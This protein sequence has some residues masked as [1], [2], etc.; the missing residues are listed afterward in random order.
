MTCWPVRV[1][2]WKE[3]VPLH[4]LHSLAVPQL[5]PPETERFY[6]I[7]V[8]LLHYVNAQRHLVPAFPATWEE[9]TEEASVPLDAVQP[10]RDALWAEDTLRERFI[11]DNP[12]GLPTADLAL[13]A[14]WQHRVAGPFYIFRYLKKHTL[15]LSATSPAY[16][17]DGLYTVYCNPYNWYCCV[18]NAWCD[19]Y[20]G[21]YNPAEQCA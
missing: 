3:E 2:R 5:P 1:Q 15:F 18:G 13:V 6:R 9:A 4:S 7:W 14:S 19:Q 11:A 10:L 16:T 20:T 21:P 8:A 17:S 12:T